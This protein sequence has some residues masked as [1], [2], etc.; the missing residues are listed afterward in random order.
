MYYV[1]FLLDASRKTREEVNTQ[2]SLI[3]AL[4]N[5]HVDLLEQ[6]LNLEQERKIEKE[7]LSSL[8][9]E[10]ALKDDELLHRE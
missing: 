6:I 2:Q 7:F 10:L 1:G 3:N 5:K 4:E 9:E 8:Q